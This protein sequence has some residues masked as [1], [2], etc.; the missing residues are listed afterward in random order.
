MQKKKIIYNYYLI[1]NRQADKEYVKKAVTEIDKIFDLIL[2]SDYFDE[3]MVLLSD[4]LCWPIEEFA[5]LTLNARKHAP[6]DPIDEKRI[7]EKVCKFY[8]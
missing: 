2:V 3:S 6:H 7:R 8:V 5:C 1:I 4:L